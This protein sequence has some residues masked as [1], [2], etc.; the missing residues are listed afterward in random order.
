[1]GKL[2]KQEKELFEKKKDVIYRRM[3]EKKKIHIGLDYIINHSLYTLVKSK[4]TDFICDMY[5]DFLEERILNT[6]ERFFT[7]Y[8]NRKK[9]YKRGLEYI[10]Y[11]SIFTKVYNFCKFLTN[12]YRSYDWSYSIKFDNSKYY[13]TN[14]NLE[15]NRAIYELRNFVIELIHSETGDSYHL[16]YNTALLKLMTFIILHKELLYNQ[17][18][19]Q[20]LLLSLEDNF[21]I[22]YDDCINNNGLLEEG[23]FS[24]SEEWFFT[25]ETYITDYYEKNKLKKEIL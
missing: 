13:N 10:N 3:K 16:Y 12:K 5:M 19:Y 15:D 7:E 17:E 8:E 14:W 4:N 21:S 18:Y 23:F 9:I 2:T 1:M 24:L 25:P 11:K 6:T 20:K 22:Y